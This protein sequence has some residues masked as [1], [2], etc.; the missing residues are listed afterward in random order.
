MD[1]ILLKPAQ[2]T[3]HMILIQ[4]LFLKGGLNEMCSI[5]IYV[6]NLGIGPN[7]SLNIS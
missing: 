3:Q 2:T 1:G 4:E 5:G 7:L 6:W